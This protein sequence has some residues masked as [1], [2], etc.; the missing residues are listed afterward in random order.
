MTEAE[1]ADDP[2]P[3]KKGKEVGSL[4]PGDYSVHILIEAAKEI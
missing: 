4:K 3:A 2:K 1:K